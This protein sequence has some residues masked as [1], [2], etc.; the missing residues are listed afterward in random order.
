MGRG[1]NSQKA[2]GRTL[3]YGR[4][5]PAPPRSLSTLEQR[6]LKAFCAGEVPLA[7]GQLRTQRF[8]FVGSTARTVLFEADKPIAT[9]IDDS[10]FVDHAANSEL[11]GE[12]EQVVA[13]TADHFIP[14]QTEIIQTWADE[15]FGQAKK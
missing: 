10:V 6:H 12:L 5:A 1:E 15:M 4:R 14:I 11:V 2:S 7:V 9:R 13:P 8:E 3:F